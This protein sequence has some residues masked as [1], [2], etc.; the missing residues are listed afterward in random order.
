MPVRS[1]MRYG[2]LQIARSK[3]RN[4][5]YDS[6][7]HRVLGILATQVIFGDERRDDRLEVRPRRGR[8]EFDGLT[9][10][11]RAFLQL[12]V[13]FMLRCVHPGVR[14]LSRFDGV[15]F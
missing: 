12:F 1:Q 4:A 15:G 13:L 9:Q 6:R 3:R 5:D 8:R 11:I 10:T 7:P 14:K 2:R